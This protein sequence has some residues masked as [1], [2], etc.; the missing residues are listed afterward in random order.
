ML[1][2][3]TISL[4]SVLASISSAR[5]ISS[6][7]DDLTPTGPGPNDKFKSG[8]DCVITFEPDTSGSN[9]WKNLTIDFMTGANQD[10]TFLTNVATNI[11]GTSASSSPVTWTCPEVDPPA[12]IYFY[13]FTHGNEQ[14]PMWTTRFLITDADGNSVDPP[15]SKQP[16]SDGQDIPWG[17]GK[18]VGAVSSGSGSSSG[19]SSSQDSDATSSTDSNASQTSTSTSAMSTSTSSSATSSTSTAAQTSR[20][21]SGNSSDASKNVVS[22]SLSALV[23]VAFGMTL[24]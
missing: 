16:G 21:S 17:E 18:I 15:Q 5:Q 10:M 3:R 19:S 24:V 8:G 11:D 4:L 1:A 20:A 14:G 7:A 9:K 12:A 13:Q 6:R 23:A 2:L 22:L